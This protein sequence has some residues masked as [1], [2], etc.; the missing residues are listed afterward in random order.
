MTQDFIVTDQAS[1][2]L[3]E[4]LSEAAQ[5]FVRE[6]VY[7]DEWLWEGQRYAVDFRSA[8]ALAEDLLDEGFK[9]VTKH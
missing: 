1:V 9:V 4:P 6:N 5:R 7:F 3:F 8:G 2:W